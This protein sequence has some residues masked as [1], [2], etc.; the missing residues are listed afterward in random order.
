MKNLVEQLNESL[1]VTEST[2]NEAYTKDKYFKICLKYIKD[3]GDKL[4]KGYFEWF[5]DVLAKYYREEDMEGNFDYDYLD[6][7]IWNSFGGAGTSLY[8]IARIILCKSDIYE[9]VE[10][11]SESF[12]RA[13]ELWDFYLNEY[14]D[15]HKDNSVL[16]IKTPAFND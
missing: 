8:W 1:V 10:E 2:V 7:S 11:D 3:K 5:A 16:K 13:E 6:G 9:L 12:S 15:S 4:Y 14:V